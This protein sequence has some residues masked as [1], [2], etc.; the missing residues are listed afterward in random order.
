M[1]L[2]S[3]KFLHDDLA[4]SHARDSDQRATVCMTSPSLR[5]PKSLALQVR[6]ARVIWQMH[7]T[8]PFIVAANPH[9]QRIHDLYVDIFH[10]L[11]TFPTITTEKAEVAFTTEFLPRFLEEAQE[12]I[13]RLAK[14][15][16]VGSRGGGAGG[17][18]GRETEAIFGLY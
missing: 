5:L 11:I 10:D 16:K 8:L 4:V 14:A 9:F 6:L 7:N 18:F 17:L 13:P 1:L 2:T 15:S 3:A 12:V